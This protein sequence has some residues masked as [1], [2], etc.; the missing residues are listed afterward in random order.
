MQTGL[1]DGIFPGRGLRYPKEDEKEPFRSYAEIAAL[2]ESQRDRLWECLYLTKA[3]IEDAVTH[4][5]EQGT[6]PWV[7]PMVAFAAYT[8]ARRSELLRALVVDVNLN[9]G[10]VAIREKSA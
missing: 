10:T 4:V 3:E 2:P 5:R 6:L 9:G 8:G 7:Y 1:L